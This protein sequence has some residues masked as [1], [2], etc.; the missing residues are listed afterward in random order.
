MLTPASA[1]IKHAYHAL[2]LDEHRKPFDA[3]LWHFPADG[4]ATPVQPKGSSTKLRENWEQLRDT[5]GA[6]E[7]Q[8]ATAWGD[9]VV[10]EMHEE[11]KGHDSKLLQVWFPGVHINVGGGSDDLLK[12]KKGDFERKLLSS[13]LSLTWQIFAPVLTANKKLP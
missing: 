9:L 10:A 1:D 11:L 12:D 3:T 4:V 7:Q 2:A 13:R 6:T 8:L 5:D